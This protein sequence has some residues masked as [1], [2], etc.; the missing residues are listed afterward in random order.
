MEKNCFYFSFTNYENWEMFFFVLFR[1]RGREKANKIGVVLNPLN[2]GNGR[3]VDF[4]GEKNRRRVLWYMEKLARVGRKI[5]GRD[6]LE[7][8]GENLR[9]S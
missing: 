5:G 3:G 4:G 8:V 7:L 9:V 2:S 6:G 1:E